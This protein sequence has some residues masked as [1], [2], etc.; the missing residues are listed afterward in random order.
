MVPWHQDLATLFGLLALDEPQDLLDQRN[1]KV[2]LQPPLPRQ[3]QAL[4][5]PAQVPGGTEL[6]QGHWQELIRFL[7]QAV[8]IHES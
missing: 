4:A 1:T 8:R 5:Q 3:S 7:C 2:V 6:H